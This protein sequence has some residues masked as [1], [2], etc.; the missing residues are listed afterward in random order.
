MTNKEFIVNADMSVPGDFKVIDDAVFTYVGSP[1]GA[2]GGFSRDGIVWQSTKIPYSASWKNPVYGNNIFATVAYGGSDSLYSVDG[3]NWLAYPMGAFA[4]WQ[5]LAYGNG[6]FVTVAYGTSTAKY[7][8]DGINWITSTL[9]LNAAWDRVV[10][11][12]NKFIAFSRISYQAATSTNGIIWTQSSSP[13]NYF[14]DVTFGNN[15]FV[16]ILSNNGAVRSSTDGI[17]WTAGTGFDNLLQQ[18]EYNNGIF[19]IYVTG[20]NLNSSTDAITWNSYTLPMGYGSWNLSSGNGLFILTNGTITTSAIS[21]NGITWTLGTQTNTAY[22]A[23]AAG[24]ISYNAS[25][26]IYNN[27]GLTS[28]IKTQL[29]TKINKL[30]PTTTNSILNSSTLTENIFTIYSQNAKNLL[31]STD[32]V[33][34]NIDAMPVADSG[35]GPADVIY[36]NGKYILVYSPSDKFYTSSDQKTWQTITLPIYDYW[37]NITIGQ[38][39]FV[40]LASGSTTA[41][42]STDGITWNLRTTPLIDTYWT[43][44]KYGNGVFVAVSDSTTAIVSTNGITWTVRTLPDIGWNGLA[45]GN[46]TFL[47]VQPTF[48]N[49][50]ASTNGTTWT[51]GTISILGLYPDSLIYANNLFLA[52]NGTDE[53]AGYSTDGVSW[54]ETTLSSTKDWTGIS[55]SNGLWL[56]PAFNSTAISVSTDAIIWTERTLP[57]VGSWNRTIAIPFNPSINI[58]KITG[59]LVGPITNSTYTIQENDKYIVFTPTATCTITLPNAGSY[60]GREITIKNTSAFAVN[61]ASANI[62]PLTTNTAGTTI[63]A[64]T[65]G[66][67]AKIIS[68]GYDWTVV[69]SN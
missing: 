48:N 31:T 27:Y 65:A 66:K 4:S 7:S 36:A 34:W 60:P 23:A 45:Y 67:F 15:K 46:G 3:I 47:T 12:N 55:Y 25:N 13:A 59:N 24:R 17:T 68:N 61:S 44:F 64:A 10:Y 53:I 2:L 54:T 69:K 8:T 18:I 40:A 41:I 33:T 51:L 26:L 5:E 20:G 56:A 29:D 30:S 42:S 19:L 28:S 21:T 22:S 38:G 43:G 14:S 50:A 49:T 57:E 58:K 37:S 35:S 11:G 39:T 52:T 32:A 63:L 9:P 1:D 16:M 6:I 62:R